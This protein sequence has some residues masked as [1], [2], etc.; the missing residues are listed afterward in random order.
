MLFK[1][2]LSKIFFPATYIT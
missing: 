1:T 2:I